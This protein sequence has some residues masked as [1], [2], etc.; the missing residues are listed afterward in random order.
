MRV[1][2]YLTEAKV[3]DR[4]PVSSAAP[5]LAI[6]LLHFSAWL[7]CEQWAAYQQK[8][9]LHRAKQLSLSSILLPLAHNW[10]ADTLWATVQS[11]YPASPS[12]PEAGCPAAAHAKKLFA[13]ML[14]QGERHCL[15]LRAEHCKVGL[16]VKGAAR[17]VES[18]SEAFRQNT[19]RAHLN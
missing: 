3:K 4:V 16:P 13:C 1:T 17:A 7:S 12:G 18:L 8:Q 6:Y 9:P 19:A 5:I 2:L 14:S 11:S 10:G 15:V